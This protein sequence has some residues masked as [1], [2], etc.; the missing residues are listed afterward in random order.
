MNSKS[1]NSSSKKRELI[2]PCKLRSKNVTD[3]DDAVLCD[4]CQ[5]WVHIKCNHLLTILT[6]NTYKVVMSHAIVSLV[7]IDFFHLVI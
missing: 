6:T 3:N 5:V 1:N 4:L 7:P 2:F